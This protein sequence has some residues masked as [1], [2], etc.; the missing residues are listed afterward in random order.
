MAEREIQPAPS[1]LETSLCK[2]LASI[3]LIGGRKTS[4]LS[5]CKPEDH[6]GNHVKAS[7]QLGKGKSTSQ[8]LITTFIAKDYCLF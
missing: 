3:K 4:S 1:A 6:Q 5:C 2:Y 7:T 8:S